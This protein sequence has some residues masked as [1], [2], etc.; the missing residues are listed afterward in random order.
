MKTSFFSAIN[1][2]AKAISFT[3][4][5]AGRGEHKISI[6]HIGLFLWKPPLT[7]HAWYG[8]SLMMIMDEEFG[9]WVVCLRRTQFVNCD[10]QL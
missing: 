7:W 10:Y 3:I 1:L 6:A 2:N 8:I 4:I 5:G 9:S